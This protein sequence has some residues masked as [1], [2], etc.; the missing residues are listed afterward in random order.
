[1]KPKVESLEMNY[2]QGTGTAIIVVPTP[3]KDNKGDFPPVFHHLEL[4][5]EMW[6]GLAPDTLHLVYDEG[7]YPS[8]VLMDV[9]RAGKSQRYV[10]EFEVS[11]A[12]SRTEIEAVDWGALI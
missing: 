3:S 9:S 7:M 11:K 8:I 6:C 2:S 10:V 4:F 5:V 1:V 12:D